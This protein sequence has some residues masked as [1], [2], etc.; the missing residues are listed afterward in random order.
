MSK[1]RLGPY[2]FGIAVL[3]F[4]SAI[5]PAFAEVM[6]IETNLEQFLKGDKIKFSGTVEKYSKGIVSIVIRDGDDKFITLE[7]AAID[8]D[9]TFERTVSIDS[10]FESDGTY[11]ANGFILSLEKSAI[12]TFEIHSSMPVSEVEVVEI[13]PSENNEQNLSNTVQ[14]VIDLSFIDKSKDPQHYIDRYYNETSYKEW[15]D[16]NYPEIT[17][18]EAVGYDEDDKDSSNTLEVPISEIITPEIIPIAEASSNISDSSTPKNGHIP[19]ISLAVASLGILF[20]AVYGVKRKV[21]HNSKQISLNRDMLQ[22][23]LIRPIIGNDPQSILKT[24]LAKGQI[25]IQEYEQ[26]KSKLN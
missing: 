24:R 16:R 20:G 12:T 3:L 13:I 11:Q 23:K 10:M 14:N 18:E 9:Y 6:T 25:S 15:F 4:V 26:L 5:T 17:I 19:E 1:N 21:D 22:K 8:P 7:Q 2:S